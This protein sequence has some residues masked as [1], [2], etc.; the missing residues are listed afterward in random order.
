S[1]VFAAWTAE[2]KGLL[3]SEY[4]AANP[5]YP[6]ETTVA[7]F[8]VDAL[9]PTG[10][11]RDVLVVGYGQ[12]ELE[13]RLERVLKSGG[14]VIAPDPHPEAGYFFRSDHFPLAKRGV[15][16]LDVG[17]GVDLLSGGT[18]AGE[19]ADSA[20]RQDRY[21]QPADEYDA[22][23][24]N[25]QGSAQDMTALQRLGLELATSRDWPNYRA[26]SE[27]RPVRD[28]SAARRH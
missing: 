13:D 9:S 11:A 6:L 25:L 10:P 21:H 3:G 4:Y 14:R 28:A 5:V 12:S 19:A 22:P 1:I 18:K 8:N 2:E 26:T 24:W 20:Y 16:M 7:G 27:F 15:P 17:S 23:T